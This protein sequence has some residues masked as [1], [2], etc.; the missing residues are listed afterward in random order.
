MPIITCPNCGAKNRVDDNRARGQQP[1]CGRCGTKLSLT[2]APTGGAAAKPIEVTD[3]TFDALV[4]Q[5]TVPVLV[6]CWAPWCGPCRMIAPTMEQL[7]AESNG[8]YLIAKLNTDDNRGVASEYRIDA[9]PTM[10]IFHHGQLVDR[11]VG[12]QPKP[13]ILARL[14]KAA[15]AAV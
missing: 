4:R 9:I 12:L 2:T 11:V 8:R 1:V 14:E 10:L 15:S 5:A 13:A 3:A 7:A 6:D